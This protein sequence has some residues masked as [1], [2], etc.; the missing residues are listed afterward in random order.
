MGIAPHHAKASV[1]NTLEL[2]PRL[3]H[4]EM[5]GGADEGSLKEDR[6]QH[7]IDLRIWNVFARSSRRYER[8]L[9]K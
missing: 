2:S 6:R 1:L 4:G 7:A 5:I 3:K 8:E 9:M